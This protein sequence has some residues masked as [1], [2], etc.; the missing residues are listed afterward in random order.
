MMPELIETLR[1]VKNAILLVD[2]T[3][4]LPLHLKNENIDLAVK[5]LQSCK[6]TNKTIERCW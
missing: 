1:F 6:D 2:Q 3:K 5:M 4:D